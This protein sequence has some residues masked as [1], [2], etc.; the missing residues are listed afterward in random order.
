MILTGQI[1]VK[2]SS[3]Q[4]WENVLLE[5][6]I[7]NAISTTHRLRCFWMWKPQ[8]CCWCGKNA[9]GLL[10]LKLLCRSLVTAQELKFRLASEGR[11][12]AYFLPLLLLFSQVEAQGTF[13]CRH[14]LR[15]LLNGAN[16]PWRAQTHL[17]AVHRS[18][19]KDPIFRAP[20][21]P[22]RY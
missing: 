6:D 10:E 7:K 1:G 9:S 22:F 3:L 5:Q 13:C 16:A 11:S 17:V 19:S 21:A 18:G 12:L 2:C 14:F 8:Q 15:G 4:V 20:N